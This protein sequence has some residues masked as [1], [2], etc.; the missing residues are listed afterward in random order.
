[1]LKDTETHDREAKFFIL[2]SSI[3]WDEIDGLRSRNNYLRKSSNLRMMKDR[4]F[5]FVKPNWNI[6]HTPL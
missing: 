1:M 6:Y 3:M 5:Q 2:T 4:Y